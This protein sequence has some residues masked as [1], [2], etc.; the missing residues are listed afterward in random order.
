MLINKSMLTI[1]I[2]YFIAFGCAD[3]KI[4]YP[5]TTTEK[6]PKIFDNSGTLRCSEGSDDLDDVCDYRSIQRKNY[7]IMWIEDIASPDLIRY[8]VFKFDYK[9]DKFFARTG[10]PIRLEKRDDKY[11]INVANSYYLISERSLKE[12][13]SY[14][15]E[16]VF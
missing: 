15:R 7:T 4:V 9:T 5:P 13:Y 16:S 12:G 14:Q 10:E 6:G 1:I 3:K 8:R 11:F 2:L